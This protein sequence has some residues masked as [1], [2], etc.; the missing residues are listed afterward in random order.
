M[1]RV[2]ALN[3]AL[4]AG[5]A[6]AW[7]LEPALAALY[8]AAF[9][10]QCAL[11]VRRLNAVAPHANPDDHVPITAAKHANW[12][13]P[14]P[15]ELGL[16]LKDQFD[17]RWETGETGVPQRGDGSPTAVR[18]DAMQR[19]MAGAL[20]TLG[21]SFDVKNPA[22]RG[23]LAQL[24]RKITSI[25]DT[26]RIDIMRA[27]D[28]GWEKGYSIPHVADLIRTYATEVAPARATMIART[29]LIGAVNGGSHAVATIA[30]RYGQAQG[31]PQLLKIWLSAEDEKVRDDHV[32]AASDYGSGNGIALDEPFMVGGAPM[33]YPGDP[34]GPADE[35]I[36]C[37]CAISY[38]DAEQ[39]GGGVS[40]VS[41]DAA[42][43][44]DATTASATTL[45]GTMSEQHWNGRAL[46]ATGARTLDGTPVL[47]L[48]ELPSI[49][50][51]LAPVSLDGARAWTSVLCLE[52]I[53]TGDGRMLAIDAIGWRDLPLTLMAMLTTDEGHDGAIICGRIDEIERMPAAQALSA[54]L[55][56]ERD[57]G[58]PTDAVALVGR[59]VFDESWQA[60]EV[61]RLV[62]DKTLR[63]V[64]VDL[65]TESSEVIELEPVGDAEYGDLLFLVTLGKIMGATVCPFPA[66]AEATIMLEPLE[67]G[68]ELG[69]DA[70]PEATAEAVAASVRAARDWHCTTNAPMVLT[71]RVV[72]AAAVDYSDG[73]MVAVHP[74]PE[75]SSAMAVTGGQVDHHVTLAF[76]PDPGSVDF[77]A[78][79]K[80]VAG[81]AAEHAPLSGQVGGAGYFAAA[82]QGTKKAAARA[83]EKAGD[84]T[85]DAEPDADAD[86]AVAAAGAEKAPPVAD[87][88]TDADSEGDNAKGGEGGDGNDE[89][90]HP[91]VA[92]VDAPGLSRM[93][94]ALCQA[95]DDAGIAYAQ[96]HDFTPHVTLAYEPTPNVPAMHLAGQPLTFDHMVVHE[97][98]NRTAHPLGGETDAP[99]GITASAAGLAPL[100]PP[101]GWFEDPAF[102]ELTPLTVTPEGRI[103]GH[104][105][106][107]GACHVG[108]ADQCVQPPPSPSG[109]ALFHLG[110]VET[111]D[112]QLVPVGTL[113]LDTGHADLKLGSTAARMHY[114]HTGTAAAD[115]RVG[116]DDHGI[117]FTGAIRPELDAFSVRKLRAAKVSGDWRPVGGDLELVAA[118]SVN[119]PGFPV[120]RPRAAVAASG[121]VLAL[122]AAGI[123]MRPAPADVSRARVL[124]LA[125]QARPGYM[126]ARRER[127]FALLER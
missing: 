64:S 73:C 126:A 46:V 16:A 13:K 56:P 52:G 18:V 108:I 61:M 76:I 27:I 95:M 117:W 62:G 84:S 23:V 90:L 105:A 49:V 67:P 21:L 47:E 106:P 112:G 35:V 9:K 63:G 125:E 113:T 116:E 93:R 25:A 120:V 96:N 111:D 14:D 38:E 39:P 40:D 119:V 26:T 78:L 10:A 28:D 110:D 19:V 53:P 123:D 50:N 85:D 107:W 6:A 7:E 87:A 92:L 69:P 24:G 48:A 104:L 32:D 91:H 71:R 20:E 54:G 30:N 37:R 124:A 22:V 55:L 101:A 72:T 31:Q 1:T 115:V 97:G 58:Y 75:Q 2:A 5:A 74:T 103:Y 15:D 114:D 109:Y 41:P 94:S 36:N 127:L 65:A 8:L 122:V 17:D 3:R 79:N 60:D 118:L 59:G 81:V 80:V 29:E 34:D 51:D 66:F 89:P 44:D 12:S 121:R 82:P 43:A 70:T 45:E 11:A 83:G 88:E 42:P 4:D 77:A 102:E 98:L 100:H 68:A 86:D 33:Q 57:G 99:A